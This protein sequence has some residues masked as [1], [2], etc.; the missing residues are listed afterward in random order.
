VPE[1]KGSVTVASPET[2]VALR[3]LVL[4]KFTSS[5]GIGVQVI[6]R[7]QDRMAQFRLWELE[8]IELASLPPTGANVR[9][10]A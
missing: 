7:I 3:R 4:Q 6:S 1:N 5:Y 2:T 10:E 9:G 8:S